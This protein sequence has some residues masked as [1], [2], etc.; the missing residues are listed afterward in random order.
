VICHGSRDKEV[1]MKMPRFEIAWIMGFIAIVALNFGAI[2]AAY[3]YDSRSVGPR[4][5]AVTSPFDT[6]REMLVRGALPMAN[7][8]AIGLL[9]GLRRRNNHP[10]LLGFE[11]F[12]IV[13]LVGYCV[14]AFFVFPR[15]YRYNDLSNFIQHHEL[16]PEFISSRHALRQI[17]TSILLVGPQLA[18]AMVGGFVSRKSRRV[19]TAHHPI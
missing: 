19:S 6:S 9:I 2:R 15:H 3:A 8:L 13:A 17:A 7:I 1:A 18:M 10:S 16:I 12:G 14:W 11:S 5:L 4:G